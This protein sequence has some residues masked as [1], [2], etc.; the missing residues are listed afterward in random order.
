[1]GVLI[2]ASRN[3]PPSNPYMHQFIMCRCILS[4]TDILGF[5]KGETG[6]NQITGL[7]SEWMT[8]AKRAGG[9]V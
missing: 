2:Y 7:G 3:R 5:F 4:K 1:M 6:G 9:N 8:L